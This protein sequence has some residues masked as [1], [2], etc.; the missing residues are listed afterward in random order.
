MA[1]AMALKIAFRRSRTA[2][3]A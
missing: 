1:V 3:D 2:R